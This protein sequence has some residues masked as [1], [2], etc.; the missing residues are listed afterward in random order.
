MLENNLQRK[1]NLPHRDLCRIIK[2]TKTT[3]W[4]WVK[5]DEMVGWGREVRA[6]EYV[7][8]LG[9]ELDI[10]IFAEFLDVIVLNKGHIDVEQPR[11]ND[12]VARQIAEEI[13]ACIGTKFGGIYRIS[14]VSKNETL[15]TLGVRGIKTRRCRRQDKTLGLEILKVARLNRILGSATG[16]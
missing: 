13:G 7:E 11:S 12:R 16:S 1:L 6:I 8:Q 5:G 2:Q 3:L 15:I 10:E 9:A 14:V 4:I